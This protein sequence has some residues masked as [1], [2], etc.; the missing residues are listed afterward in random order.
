MTSTGKWLPRGSPGYEAILAKDVVHLYS[1]F[2]DQ[3]G[4]AKGHLSHRLT[5]VS[6]EATIRGRR[7]STLAVHCCGWCWRGSCS[8]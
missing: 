1:V 2:C 4:F 7:D 6:A 3:S 8:A 5:R